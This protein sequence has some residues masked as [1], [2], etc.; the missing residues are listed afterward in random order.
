M[1][2]LLINDLTDSVEL[3]RE[4]MTAIVGG[5]RIGT[6][7]TRA[8]PLVPVAARVV[9]Y[10]PGFPAAHQAIGKVAATRDKRR[11]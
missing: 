5:A 7:L 3:D 4:A 9:E 2:R 10:P 1:A 6:R 11:G 8:A